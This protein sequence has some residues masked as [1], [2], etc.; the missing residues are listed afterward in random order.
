MK[1]NEVCTY[2][3]FD[4]RNCLISSLSLLILL[5]VYWLPSLRIHNDGEIID[6]TRSDSKFYCHIR[7]VLH[8]IIII[9]LYYA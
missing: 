3:D 4:D 8:A 9:K 2:L 7:G 5:N 1:R 6:I